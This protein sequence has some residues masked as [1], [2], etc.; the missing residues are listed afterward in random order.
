MMILTITWYMKKVA[1]HLVKNSDMIQ[2]TNHLKEINALWLFK[3]I[4][5]KVCQVVLMVKNIILANV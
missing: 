5:P 4:I 3:Y 2:N 1:M